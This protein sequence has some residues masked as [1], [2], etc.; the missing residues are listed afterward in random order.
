MPT[1]NDPEIKDVFR[2]LE[3]GRLNPRLSAPRVPDFIP[4][5]R[6]RIEAC[7]NYQ[8]NWPNYWNRIRKTYINQ[9][10]IGRDNVPPN[11]DDLPPQ[12]GS[13]V[14]ANRPARREPP[15]SRVPADLPAQALLH[16]YTDDED[17][18][19]SE[20]SFQESSPPSMPTVT[21]SKEY[22]MTPTTNNSTAAKADV[23]PV[24]GVEKV[25]HLDTDG[26]KRITVIASGLPSARAHLT[27]V[28]GGCTLSLKY[29]KAKGAL[30]HNYLTDQL[31]TVYSD[32]LCS[33]QKEANT[34]LFK[35]ALLDKRNNTPTTPMVSSFVLCVQQQLY[36]ELY[37]EL[38]YVDSNAA[39]S[40]V[41]RRN[42]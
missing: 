21:P 2:A 20:P 23:K 27:Q 25:I 29:G 19:F 41:D 35:D 33:A 28:T 16:P 14:P 22:N 32:R 11:P 17:L 30:D 37:S 26:N 8:K 10:F 3:S 15:T 18:L 5:L 13:R 24:I 4:S 39:F 36:F 1:K 40:F 38:L 31:D 6:A 12:A 34:K 42:N 7:E 9:G